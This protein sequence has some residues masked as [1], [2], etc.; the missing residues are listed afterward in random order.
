MTMKTYYLMAIIDG[1]AI[2]NRVLTPEEI[3]QHYQ[4]GF[5]GLVFVGCATN[6]WVAFKHKPDISRSLFSRVAG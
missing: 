2:Y 6:L 5:A 4:N 3:H 1:F